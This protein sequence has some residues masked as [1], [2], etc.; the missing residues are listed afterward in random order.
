VKS[1]DG[2][3]RINDAVDW[4]ERSDRETAALLRTLLD[5][6]NKYQAAGGYLDM[7]TVTR[8]NNVVSRLPPQ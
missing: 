5:N 2:W 1:I 3:T 4:R 6:V 7:D 8:L